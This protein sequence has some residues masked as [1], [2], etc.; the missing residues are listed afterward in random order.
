M[1]KL[2]TLLVFIFLV[3]IFVFPLHSFAA[4]PQIKVNGLPST[5]D[6]IVE[7][8]ELFLTFGDDNKVSFQERILE[9]RLAELFYATNKDVDLVEPTASRYNTYAQ[10]LN[11]Y[12]MNKTV[13]NKVVE[14]EDK[15]SKH[16]QILIELQN[17]YKSNSGW[18]LAI[19]QSV[20][21]DKNIMMNI[22]KL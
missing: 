15:L 2:I 13:K 5:V 19:Q 11:E 22:R 20:D 17:K 14:V 1:K 18:W 7:K 12:M 3:T 6:K 16:V 4:E 21:S 9:K 10:R 8:I